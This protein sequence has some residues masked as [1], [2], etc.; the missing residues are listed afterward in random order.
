M[1]APVSRSRPLSRCGGL[2]VP[3]LSGVGRF[4]LFSELALGLALA[5]R[6]AATV[7]ML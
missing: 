5:Q 1:R 4:G 7:V 2:P 6:A 3:D